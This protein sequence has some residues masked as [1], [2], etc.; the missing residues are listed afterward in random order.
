MLGML[1]RSTWCRSVSFL[2]LFLSALAAQAQDVSVFEL[3]DG[4][5]VRGRMK[6]FVAGTYTIDTDSLG[7]VRIPENKIRTIQL[8]SRPDRTQRRVPA[9]APD[10]LADQISATQQRMLNDP[11]IL[12][13]ILSLQDDPA[14]REVLD[15]PATL[16]AVQAGDIAALLGNPKFLKLLDSPRLHDIEKKVSR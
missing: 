16:A 13:H 12:G 8:E 1:E 7:T 11:A 15:D 5:T 9:K 3:V 6:S 10:E 4:S 2:F 14:F